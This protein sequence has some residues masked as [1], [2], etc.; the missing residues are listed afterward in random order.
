MRNFNIALFFSFL[1]L[2]TACS[3]N[4]APA[5]LAEGTVSF[6]QV[7]GRDTIEMPLSILKDSAIV[8]GIKAALSGTVSPGEHWVTFGVDTNK[9]TDYRARYGGTVLLLPTSSYLFY[10]P[11]TRIAAGQS[12]SDSAYLNIGQQTKLTEYSTYVLPVVIRSVD[13]KAEGVA[14]NRVIYFVFKTGKPLFVS[15]LGWTITATSQNGTL[16]PATILDDNN[17]TTYWASNIT[18]AMPQS[19][20]INFNRDVSFIAVNYYLPTALNYP[21]LGGYPTSV[22]IETSMNGTTWVNKGIFAG[23]IAGN[24]QMLAIGL[25]TARYLRFTSLAVVKY[26]NLYDAVFISGISLTP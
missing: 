5:A 21:A 17:L 24:T 13:G 11:T 25:T 3:K 23:S 16:A 8:L 18:Q 9:I 14:T 4:D 20:T 12:V 1:S 15:K 22:Q 7:A 26:S 2:L 10:K 19:V 6:E